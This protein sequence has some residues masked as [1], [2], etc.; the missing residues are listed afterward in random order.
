MPLVLLERMTPGQ[1]AQEIAVY[2]ATFA[3]EQAEWLATKPSTSED[4]EFRSRRRKERARV[5]AS[6]D[7]LDRVIC[8][9]YLRMLKE[10]AT[11][12]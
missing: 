3:R 1:L 12:S 7:W 4:P 9:L 11:D 2:L 10:R 8:E 6:T 5:E